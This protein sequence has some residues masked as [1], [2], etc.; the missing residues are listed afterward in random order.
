MFML[1]VVLMIILRGEG[2]S[3]S[4]VWEGCWKASRCVEA[5]EHVHVKNLKP[6]PLSHPFTP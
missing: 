6:R 2:E 1:T 3:V 5:I 4:Y